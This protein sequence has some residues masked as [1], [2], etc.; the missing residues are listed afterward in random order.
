MEEF[1]NYGGGFF[2]EDTEEGLPGPFQSR[3]DEFQ[4]EIDSEPD[5][6]DRTNVQ[7][8]TI[9]DSIKKAIKRQIYVPITCK[10]FV[11]ASVCPDDIFY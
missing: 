10:M 9:T 4:P 3:N 5:N 1:D 2:N 8:P 11:N 6:L 7:I